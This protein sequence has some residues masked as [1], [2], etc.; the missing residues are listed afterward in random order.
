[1][2]TCHWTMFN[3]SGMFRVAES[4]VNNER[5]IGLD[6][7]LCDF[8]RPDD[9][10]EHLNADIHVT[11]THFPDSF[12]DKITSSYKTVW[13]GHGVVEHAFQSSVEANAN[14][15]YGAADTWMLCQWELQHS[16]ASVT[17]WP[18]QQAIWQTLCDKKTMVH[19]LPLGVEKDFWKPM[20]SRGKYLGAPSLFTAENAHY[21][22]WPLDLFICWP[23]VWPKVPNS[24]LH[25][26]YLP[27][28][29]HRWF[30][31]LVNRNG[32]AYRATISPMKFEHS[33]LRN[34]FCSVDFFIG[35]VRYGEANRLFLE[36]SASGVKT[37]SYWG[38]TYSDYWI[39]EGDQRIMAEELTAILKGEIEPRK[40]DEV[41]DAIETAKAMKEVYESL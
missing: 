1:M 27:T 38:N 41:P 16:D 36:A 31:P 3:N 37:I 8:S 4:L 6:S 9:Y 13:I 35:L 25:A 12:R 20:E 30:F 22:K 33:E 39:H 40:K 24:H 7:Y 23:W 21:C 18:R 5:K 14:N 17:F 15:T 11:H 2:K 34:A 32:C 19:L 26:I 28:D 10:L 29:Q